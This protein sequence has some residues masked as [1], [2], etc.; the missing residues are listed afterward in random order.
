[1]KA[2]HNYLPTTY[3]LESQIKA[4]EEKMKAMRKRAA[5]GEISPDLLAEFLP[6]LEAEKARVEEELEKASM[7][8]SNVSDKF[9]FRLLQPA[10]T[11]KRH[12]KTGH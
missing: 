5:F 2:S 3:K 6:E 1:M 9:I 8:I 11:E 7:K 10:S 4:V 12:K